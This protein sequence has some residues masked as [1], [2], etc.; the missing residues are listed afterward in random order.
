V[1]VILVGMKHCGKPTLGSA[2]A[3]L[4]VN[5]DGLDADA[6]LEKPCRCTEEGTARMKAE[7]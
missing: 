2:L 6:T 5:L 7:G 4:T 1:N 3:S